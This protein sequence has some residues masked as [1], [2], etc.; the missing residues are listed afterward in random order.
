[1]TV[2][3]YNEKLLE[4]TK[5]E[6]E[7]KRFYI[8]AKRAVIN[9]KKE[10]CY[11]LAEQFKSKIGKKVVVRYKNHIGEEITTKPGFLKEFRWYSGNTF[12]E[13]GLYP[14]LTKPK[15]DGSM[16]NREFPEYDNTR[17]EITKIVGIE[18]VL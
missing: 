3:E 12:V 10:H 2:D 18:E 8:D 6:I 5:K 4:L 15:K 17:A 7:A 1:M 13:D 11:S 16:S 9:L 14:V